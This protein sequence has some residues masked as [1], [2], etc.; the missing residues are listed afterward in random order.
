MTQV[1]LVFVFVFAAT[2]SYYVEY[3][4]YFVSDLATFSPGDTPVCHVYYNYYHPGGRVG[5]PGV[6]RY[7]VVAAAGYG[8]APFVAVQEV[9]VY[10]PSP[11][12]HLR[13]TNPAP[14]NVTVRS[15]TAFTSLSAGGSG[16]FSDVA[17]RRGTELPTCGAG[18]SARCGYGTLPVNRYIPRGSSG[19]G[20]TLSTTRVMPAATWAWI[21]TDGYV[22]GA[23]PACDAGGGVT[24][25]AAG[26]DHTW[27]LGSA[28]MPSGYAAA[29]GDGFYEGCLLA[30][31]TTSTVPVYVLLNGVALCCRG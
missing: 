30:T 24:L 16:A 25:A 11:N 7:V 13:A 12:L 10:A 27:V 15:V 5:C 22:Y 2:T 4:V 31:N 1:Y 17:L 28:A 3:A 8:A 9:T 18:L 14:G 26:S 23:G 29:F 19:N 6:G 20:G 21:A